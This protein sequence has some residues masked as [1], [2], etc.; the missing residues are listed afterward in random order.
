MSELGVL[1][2]PLQQER[3]PRWA[4]ER[5]CLS[6]LSGEPCG[7]R[8]PLSV[9]GALASLL[10]P[11]S[12][13][14]PSLAL[15]RGEPSWPPPLGFLGRNLLGGCFSWKKPLLDPSSPPQVPIK[16][17]KYFLLLNKANKGEGS[18]EARICSPWLCSAELANHLRA[19]VPGDPPVCAA[20]QTGKQGAQGPRAP[21]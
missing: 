18:L 14:A 21:C 10:A 11:V 6:S 17:S 15:L 2:W 9:H 16:C 19:G 12:P 8:G 20:S 4:G 3:K 1:G 7:P 13:P 5:G